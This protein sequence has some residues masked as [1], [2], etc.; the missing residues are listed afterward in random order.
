MVKKIC[1]FT[2]GFAFNRLV[3]MKFYERIF[4]KDVELYIFTTNKFKGKEKKSYQYNWDLERTKIEVADYNL[5]KLASSLRKF[6]KENEIDRVINI[7]TRFNCVLLSFATLFL[8]T[9]YIVNVLGS[10]SDTPDKITTTEISN[11]LFLFPLILLSKRTLINDKLDSKRY[12][13]IIGKKITYLPAVVNTDLKKPG[14]KLLARKK[15][16]LPAKKKI[17]LYVGRIDYFKCSDIL[18]KLIKENP[19]I[20]FVVIGRDVDGEISKLKV[21]N[22]VYIEKKSPEELGN[23]YVAAD[24][25]FLLHRP[26]GGGL[27]LTNEESLA[28]GTPTITAI[29]REIQT[30]PA[31]FQIKPTFKM[32]NEAIH[33]FFKLSSKKRNELSKLARLYAKR[34]YSEDAWKSKY[35]EYH[36]S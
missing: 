13:R 2:M 1:F 8:K 17:V 6:C 26:T 9:D 33:N 3:R 11:F 5:F 18:L 21:K 22:L 31:L 20:F 23:Y 30:S 29:K 14:N 34:N 16:K 35:I 24:I 12:K 15:L 10:L 36:L 4:P 25:S 27:G 7:G 19:E 28:C 32:S